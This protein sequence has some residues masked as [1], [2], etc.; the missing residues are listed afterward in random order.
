MSSPLQHPV[1]PTTIKTIRLFVSHSHEDARLTGLLVDFLVS[2]AGLKRADVR[3][4][5]L[6][7]YRLPGGALTDSQI[8]H[9]IANA[10]AF[11]GIISPAAVRSPYVTF[12]L[13]ARWGTG[14]HLL[15]ILSPNSSND[16]LSGPLSGLN[17]LRCNN[18]S[19][20]MQ[21]AKEICEAIGHRK[22]ASFAP[23]FLD[24]LLRYPIDEDL[25]QITIC[26]SWKTLAYLPLYIAER[27]RFFENEGLSVN[28]TEGRGDHVAWQKV[29]TGEAKFGIGDPVVM[30]PRNGEGPSNGRTVASILNRAALWGISKKPLA[31]ITSAKQLK[32]KTVACFREPSTSFMMMKYLSEQAKTTS[33][34]DLRI[35]GMEPQS[36]NSYLDRPDIDFVLTLEPTVTEEELT[37]AHRVFSGPAYFRDFLITG[38]YTTDEVIRAEPATVQGVVNAIDRSLAYIRNNHLD[39]LRIAVDEFGQDKRLAVELATLR[40][41]AEKVFPESAAISE[42]AWHQCLRVRFGDEDVAYPFRDWVDNSFAIRAQKNRI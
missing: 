40:L 22:P 30:L 23:G 5:S 1:P 27:Q 17:V 38:I 37:G 26:Q 16:L 19:Q 28:F 4:T 3:C 31:P 34:R 24:K 7:G 42:R 32:G 9:E 33:S 11:I 35:I 20:M 10:D 8:K 6:D 39:A 13:G 18:R 25:R 41:V 21:A 2:A 14:K 12:E 29:A 15:P 36:E